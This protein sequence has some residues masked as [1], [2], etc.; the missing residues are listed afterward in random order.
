MTVQHTLGRYSHI[1]MLM[2]WFDRRRRV[3]DDARLSLPVAGTGSEARDGVG[4]MSGLYW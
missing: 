3:Y 2:Y 1:F 4:K